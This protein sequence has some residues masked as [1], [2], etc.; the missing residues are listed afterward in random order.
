M[1]LYTNF[2][3]PLAQVYARDG[4]VLLLG[5]GHDHNS[6]FHLGEFRADYSPHEET[7]AA[8]LENGQRVWKVFREMDWDSALKIRFGVPFPFPSVYPY[9]E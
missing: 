8:L 7:G 6:S 1:A 4:W 3:S 5:I 9:A 2:T